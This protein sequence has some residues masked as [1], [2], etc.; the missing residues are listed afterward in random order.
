MRSGAA[1]G[2]HLISNSPN[3]ADPVSPLGRTMSSAQSTSAAVRR[4]TRS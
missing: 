3:R 2:D 4:P 1:A